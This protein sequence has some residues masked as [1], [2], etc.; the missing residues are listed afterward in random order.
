MNDL[1][2]YGMIAGMVIYVIGYVWLI[3][4]AFRLNVVWGLMCIFIPLAWVMFF[5]RYRQ[6]A[7]KPLA[8]LFF[9]LGLLIYSSMKAMPRS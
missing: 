6:R 4:A 9:G 5:A 3:T 1:L 7:W 2:H 8:V